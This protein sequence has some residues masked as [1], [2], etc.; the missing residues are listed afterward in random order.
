MAMVLA[1]CMCSA[2][3]MYIY[4][5]SWSNIYKRSDVAVYDVAIFNYPFNLYTR[6]SSN[7]NSRNEVMAIRAVIENKISIMNI[8]IEDNA[9]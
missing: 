8:E 4:S 1:R 9:C 3:G 5:R 2:C 7:Y 6:N